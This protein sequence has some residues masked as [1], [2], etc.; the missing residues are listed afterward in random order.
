M[1][2]NVALFVAL[3]SFSIGALAEI[4]ELS[5][6]D[7]LNAK[8]TVTPAV[9]WINPVTSFDVS[10]ISG[11]DRYITLALLRSDGSTIWSTKSGLVT[12]N[13]RATSSAGF[14]YYGKTLTVPAMGED[15]FTL[16][17]IITD[18][19]GKEVSRQDY[20]IAID[21]TPPVTGT[22]TY[23]RNGWTYGSEA[24]F[25]SLPPGMQYASVQ[26]IVFNG[27]SD[28]SSGLDKAEYFITDSAGVE[29][30]KG[31]KINTVDGSVTVQIDDASGSA[32]APDARSEYTI[33]IYL[34]DK[35]GNR[36]EL[37][38]RSVIDR[39]K[40]DDIIQVQNANTGLWET[41]ESG[42]DVYQ[43]PISIRVLRKKS[44]FVSTN[45]TKYGWADSK[46]QTSDNNYNIFTFKYIY[47]SVGD[48]YYEFETLAGGV[49]RIHNNYFNFSPAS[50]L[51]MAPKIV[52]KE[53]YRSETNEW[54]KQT[55][56]S[57]QTGTISRIKV[58]AEQRNYV[59]KFRTVKEPN[60]FCTIPVGQ[61]SCEMAVNFSYTSGK[62]FEYIHLYSGKDGSNIYDS[63]A[64]N[65]SVI[66]DNNAPVINSAQINK[67]AKT[68]S[69][70]ATDND[71]VNAWNI[72]YWDTKVFQATLKN[73]RGQI[74]TL[75]PT[76]VTE[77]DFKT[78]NATFSYAGLPD[79]NYTVLDVTATDLVGNK[80]TKS[81]NTPLNIDTTLPVIGFTFNG[82]D[83]EGVLVKGLENLRISV[84]DTSG[85][86]SLTS[87]KLAGGPNSE[88]V[89]LAFTSI[90]KDVYI[91]EYPRIFPNTDE[92][93]QTYHLEALAIDGSGNQTI[94]TL[95][96]TYQPANLILLDNLK[97]LATAVALKATDNTP[98]AIIRTSVLR[99]QDGSIITGLLNGTLTVQKN[100][101]FGVTVVGVTV[102]PGET[103]SLSLDMGNGEERS[104]PVIP[105]ESGY[106]GTATFAIEFPQL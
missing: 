80:S 17:E 75:T 72:S 102:Q 10:V 73:P 59:Q 4:A 38:R 96:F 5:F 95:N 105:A 76:S 85:D 68:I 22:I 94:K 71:R 69:M 47:P 26:A 66:W 13:D 63:L 65:F 45:G 84:T 89:T 23:T 8:K 33:G 1:K 31:A 15:N 98:L 36:S 3:S 74:L 20:P 7:T 57:I 43:N 60:W 2:K 37:S 39:V 46:Y 55:S 35:A 11:L 16:R 51:E 91:P 54:L 81:L 70:T 6:K 53:M 93:D 48:T 49:R 90:S 34:Y 18:L 28:K 61:T 25:T 40:P 62:G 52:A 50:T 106:S 58:T 97:T 100:A 78:K 101:Q 29:R 88:K 9:K 32:M 99:R 67:T 79:G 82:A 64:G 44:D 87:L 12:V 92:S 56:I 30:R 21:R 14:D 103:K 24:I 83:A 104:Y 19:Q 77:S 27:L 86:A 42:M 41:Y